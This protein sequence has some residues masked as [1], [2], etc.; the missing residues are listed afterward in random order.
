MAYQCKR[1]DQSN[2]VCEY[3]VNMSTNEKVVTEK[4]NKAL[5]S[6]NEIQKWTSS[7][8]I[9]L[10]KINLTQLNRCSFQLSVIRM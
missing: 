9:S 4:Q 2:S 10:I 7:T 5:G 1:L 8:P 6:H 3:E